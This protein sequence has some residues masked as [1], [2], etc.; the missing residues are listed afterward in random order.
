MFGKICCS[1]SNP[2]MGQITKPKHHQFIFI[3]L[4]RYER[5]SRIKQRERDSRVIYREKIFEPLPKSEKEILPN[6]ERKNKSFEQIIVELFRKKYFHNR[7]KH[8]SLFLK[9]SSY[10]L[11]I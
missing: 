8:Q 1:N 9:V 4:Q 2:Q 11:K 10:F 3:L 6:S 7:K 5:K